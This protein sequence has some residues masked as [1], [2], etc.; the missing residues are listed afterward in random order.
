VSRS[1]IPRFASGGWG[2]WE[3]R[4]HLRDDPRAPI[5]LERA[6]LNRTYSVQLVRRGGLEVL[7]IRRHDGEAHFPWSDLQKIKDQLAG[8]HREAVQV[9]PR[10]DEIVDMP[11]MAH[12]WLVPDGERLPYTFAGFDR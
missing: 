11:N 8:E 1:K 9:F 10:H 5:G 12:L 2:P 6:W 3:D 7:M 4:S